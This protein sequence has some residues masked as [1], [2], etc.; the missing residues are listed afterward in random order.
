MNALIALGLGW[1]LL[2]P[3][4]EPSLLDDLTIDLRDASDRPVTLA[5]LKGGPVVLSMFYATCRHTC[6][7]LVHDIK[8]LEAALAPKE[9]AALKVLLVSLDPERDSGD[10]L[11]QAMEK[12]Q[13]DPA[14]WLLVRS[15][16]EDIRTLAAVLGIKYKGMPDGEI[17]HSTVIAVLDP[18]GRVAHRLVGLQQPID[19]VAASIRK[20]VVR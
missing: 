18:E 5:S 7:L 3:P 13:L 8:R 1:V 10:A 15:P 4:P 17:A 14:R 19:E 11:R 6:P 12:Y 2:A 9:R 16:P 20:W